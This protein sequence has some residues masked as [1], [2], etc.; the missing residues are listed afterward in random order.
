MK[1]IDGLY[2]DSDGDLIRVEG[3]QGLYIP[4]IWD[5]DLDLLW[6]AE[7]DDTITSLLLPLEFYS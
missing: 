2:E 5:L 3:G 4:V 7:E 1:Y 6:N